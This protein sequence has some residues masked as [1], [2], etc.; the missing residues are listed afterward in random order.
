MDDAS[1]TE[2]SRMG[3]L[4]LPETFSAK[5]TCSGFGDCSSRAMHA[6]TCNEPACDLRYVSLDIAWGNVARG[7]R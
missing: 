6:I 2:R 3:V 5:R 7:A 1:K 4:A